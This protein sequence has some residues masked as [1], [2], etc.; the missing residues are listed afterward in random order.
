MDYKIYHFDTIASTNL[1]AAQMVTNGTAEEGVVISTTHQ[2]QGKGQ[3]NNVW[4]SEEGK[5]LTLSIILKPTFLEASEQ[6]FLTKATS[7]ALL[8]TTQ[9]FLIQKKIQIK[10]P[11]D[12]YCEN[13]KLAGV[14]IQNFLKGNLL[15]FTIVGIGLNVNQQKFLPKTP[16]PVS[17]AQAAQKTFDLDEIKQDLLKTF[18]RFYDDIKSDKG[19][20][21][22]T[23]RYLKHLYQYQRE[24]KY[25]DVHGIFTGKIVDINNYGQLIIK[26][27]AGRKR[28]YNFKE[29]AFLH[30]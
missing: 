9:K 11:N 7:L 8:E 1:L 25:R 23:T 15:D 3:G 22:L 14:L 24:A 16:N 21:Q 13:K 20:T 4:E 6:F 17:M 28:K 2:T 29:V 12:L 26:D 27:A 10:W 30:G 18:S 19:K 5:N